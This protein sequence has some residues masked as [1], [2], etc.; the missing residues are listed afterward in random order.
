M[1]TRKPLLWSMWQRCWVGLSGTCCAQE[2]FV[3]ASAQRQSPAS[4][5]PQHM[6]EGSMGGEASMPSSFVGLCPWQP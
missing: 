3:K 6:E 2:A 5:L 1:P 4:Q